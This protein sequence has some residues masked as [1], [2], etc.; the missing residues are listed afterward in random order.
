MRDKRSHEVAA[1]HDE[2]GLDEGYRTLDFLPVDPC[3]EMKIS[4]L[5]AQQ[6]VSRRELTLILSFI[7]AIA[8]AVPV[9]SST[10]SMVM[11]N[12]PS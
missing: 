8:L 7:N 4:S 5:S 10:T 11:C 9:L 6:Q 3:V 2:V 1:D 12:G